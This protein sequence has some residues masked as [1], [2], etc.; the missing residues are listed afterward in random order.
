MKFTDSE[1]K[2]DGSYVLIYDFNR[3]VGIT[4]L[5]NGGEKRRMTFEYEYA[6]MGQTD[7]PA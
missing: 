2:E 3:N 5:G 6:A 4:L 7:S 1:K